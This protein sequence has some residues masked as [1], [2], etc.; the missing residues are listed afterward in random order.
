MEMNLLERLRRIRFYRSVRKNA[1]LYVNGVLEDQ[2]L[3]VVD[4]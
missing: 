4:V 2:G 1:D 3:E